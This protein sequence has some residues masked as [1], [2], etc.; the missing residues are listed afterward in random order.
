MDTRRYTV[1]KKWKWFLPQVQPTTSGK[2]V[3]GT[4]EGIVANDMNTDKMDAA[5]KVLKCNEVM[6]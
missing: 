2:E 1:V 3:Y 4:K 5:W 6:P